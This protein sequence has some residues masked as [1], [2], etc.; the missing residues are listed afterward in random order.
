MTPNKCVYHIRIR[1]QLDDS[2]REWLG[3][4]E[5]IH[6]RQEETILKGKITDQSE[7]F[8]ILNRIQNLGIELISIVPLEEDNRNG[9]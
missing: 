3:D 7:L 9:N 2:W 4:F 6:V 5:F 8:G 1:G